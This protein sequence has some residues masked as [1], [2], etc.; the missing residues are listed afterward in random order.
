MR[1]VI[2]QSGRGRVEWYR[3]VR[4]NS[5]MRRVDVAI[6][7][8]CLVQTLKTYPGDHS[9]MVSW[10]SSVSTALILATAGVSFYLP[11]FASH[12]NNTFLPL[13]T[14]NHVSFHA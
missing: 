6:P 12:H 4:V 10:V 13:F 11:L 1:M 8:P 3:D 14:L 7:G 2:I 5:C 9:T